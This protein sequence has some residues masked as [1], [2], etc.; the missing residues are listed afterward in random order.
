MDEAALARALTEGWIR[1][2]GL[3]VFEDEPTVHPGLLGLDNV[4]LCPHL[5]SATVGARRQMA[6]QAATNLVAALRGEEPPDRVP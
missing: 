6:V 5:G 2:A 3:D 1:A 4:V